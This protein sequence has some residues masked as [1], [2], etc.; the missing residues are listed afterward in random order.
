MRRYALL[1]LLLLSPTACS[2]AA[3]PLPDAGTPDSGA[4]EK[5]IT[6]EAETLDGP[7]LLFGDAVLAADRLDA[8]LVA[9]QLTDVYGLAYRIEYDPAVLEL[10]ALTRSPGFTHAGLFEVKEARPGLIVV[11]ASAVGPAEGIA[12]DNVAVARLGMLRR[13]EAPTQLSIVRPFGLD[14][15]GRELHFTAGSGAIVQN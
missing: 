4:V 10:D 5:T 14:S 11:A 1:A 8:D 3:L 9:H 13:T 7:A 12:L 2:K 6:F 15:A